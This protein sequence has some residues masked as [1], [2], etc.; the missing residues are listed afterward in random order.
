ML[1][2]RTD[3]HLSQVSFGSNSSESQLSTSLEEDS[4][5]MY[6]RL[7]RGMCNE[8]GKTH[9]WLEAGKEKEVNKALAFVCLLQTMDTV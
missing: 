9:L 7:F 6:M 1:I 2:G 8:R 3:S 5:S 4:H